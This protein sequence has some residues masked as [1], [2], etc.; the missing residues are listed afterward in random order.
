[1]QKMLDKYLGRGAMEGEAEG[2]SNAAGGAEAGAEAA[3]GSTILTAA[4]PA[5]KD[6]KTVP[7]GEKT[8]EQEG[9]EKEGDKTG[10]AAKDDKK[11]ENELLGAVETYDIKTPEGYDVDDEIKGEFTTAAKEIGLSQKGVERLVGIQTK[12]QERQAERTAAL[13]KDW[14]KQARSDKEIGGKDFEANAAYGRQFLA[15]FGDEQV[16]VLLDKT[17]LG[18]HPAVVKMFIRAGKAHGEATTSKGA[19]TGSKQDAATVL[20]GDGK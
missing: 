11:V 17:G 6:E 16:S 3:A 8:A 12:L 2:G 5:P 13:V 15:D 14:D 10:D 19:S 18:N 9:A 20:Y 4:P 7:E 1:M